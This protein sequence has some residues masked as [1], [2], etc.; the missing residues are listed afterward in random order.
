MLTLGAIT[1][2][3]LL[4]LFALALLRPE[5]RR[6]AV[7]NVQRRKNDTLLIILGCAFGTSIIVSSLLVGDTL[8]A[9]LRDR[10]TERLGPIDVVVSSYAAPIADAVRDFLVMDSPESADGVLAAVTADVTLV[11]SGGPA[12]EVVPSARLVEVDFDWAK[13][14]DRG[15]ASTGLNGPTPGSGEVVLGED[16]ADAL[17]VGP[18]DSVE[19][20]AYG[21][22]RLLQVTR[23]LPR[24]GIAGYA[25]EFEPESLNAFVELGTISDMIAGAGVSEDSQPP[26]QLLFVSAKGGVF[27]GA[28][29][30]SELVQQI[31]SR[32]QVLPGYDIQP[33]KRDL[34]R[35]AAEDGAEFGELFLSLGAFA[36][37]AGVALLVNVLVMLSEERRRELGILRSLGM[38]RRSLAEAFVLE[39]ALYAVAAS[40]LGVVLGIGVARLI[41]LLAGGVFSSARRGGVDLRLG[42][43]P[44]SLLLGFL[45]GLLVSMAVVA[46]ASVWIGRMTVIETIRD[47]ARRKGHN[48]GPWFR[49][50]ATIGAVASLVASGIAL[51]TGNDLGGLTLPALAFVCSAA[52]VTRFSGG[53]SS[54]PH[55]LAQTSVSVAAVGVMLWVVLAFPLLNLDVD[56]TTLF[57]VQG[58]A[59]TLA[60]IVL[61]SQ[62]QARVGSLLQKVAGGAGPVLK[63]ALTYPSDRKFRTGTT[64]L[65]YSLIVFTLVFSSVLSGVFSSQAGALADDEGGGYDVLVSTSSADPVNSEKLASIDGVESA[66]TLNW[67]VAGFRVGNSGEFQDWALSGFGQ[68]FLDGGAPALEEFDRDE[69]PNERAVWE[70][71]EREPDLAIADVAFLE[72]GGGPPEDNVAVGDEIQIK[73]PAEDVT[74]SRK[75]VGIS[76]AGA[77]F[78]GVMVSKDSLAETIENPVG[79]RHY[80]SVADGASPE[81]VATLLQGEFLEN[82]LEAR[83]FE[84]VVQQALQSQ[85]QFFNLIEGYLALGL[86]VGIA[87]LGVV[88]VRAVRE[89]RRQIGVL[90]ALGLSPAAV[91]SAFLLESG[92]VAFEGTLLGAGLA[93]VTSYQLV[94]VSTAFGDTGASFT[95][96][97]VQLVLLLVGVLAASLATTLPAAS[98]AAA[99]PPSATLRTLEEGGS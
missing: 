75:V 54:G 32:L 71:V 44:S 90:R 34:L 65:A 31:D 13:E 79:N 8:D 1:G 70:A 7:R 15:P 99:I 63:L 12:K 81:A 95:V 40:A 25:S 5:L 28:D 17:G 86:L 73:T 57:V 10:A 45:V 4:A 22:F 72:I 62:Y 36:I 41:V 50:P 58:L 33:V 64:L 80:L 35:G 27:S 60:A 97:W 51:A 66:A 87:G 53:R 61:I 96:P 89:R 26:E 93:L 30:T 43:D 82:G 77:A 88:M 92:L 52:V 49:I 98:R 67:T 85:E 6:L 39:G 29:R 74:V 69:Y 83:S 91:R 48:Q 68:D 38:N 59:L 78:S 76:A 23:V 14:F 84:E 2:A 94:V 19:A 55:S 16:T 42:V 20:Y 47:N 37:L 18:G 9:S 21:Q 11:A 46:A 24:K 3:L 56:N